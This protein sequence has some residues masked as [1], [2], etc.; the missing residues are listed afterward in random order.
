M[1]KKK[2]KQKDCWVSFKRS[3][4]SCLISCYTWGESFKVLT[5]VLLEYLHN[6]DLEWWID[7][8]RKKKLPLVSQKTSLSH[9]R[10][11][12][13]CRAVEPRRRWCAHRGRFPEASALLFC[14]QT[15]SQ[16]SHSARDRVGSLPLCTVRTQTWTSHHK[17]I[18][19][20][21]PEHRS[22][23]WG[24]KFHNNF[25]ACSLRVIHTLILHVLS[26][27]FTHFRKCNPF[28]SDRVKWYTEPG[29]AW[30]LQRLFS[31][32]SL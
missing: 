29:G 3:G 30:M 8:M 26:A 6:D 4:H 16:H 12:C 17:L 10:W 13:R 20:K 7:N 23:Y 11:S 27:L 15:R 21:T 5:G 14:R 19:D 24:K 9:P 25:A 18:V 32:C 2:K 31:T 28:I 22:N 1:I